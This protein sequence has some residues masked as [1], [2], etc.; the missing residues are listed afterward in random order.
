[1]VSS[2]MIDEYDRFGSNSDLSTIFMSIKLLGK[3]Q[4]VTWKAVD[5]W[6]QIKDT[7]DW[8]KYAEMTVSIAFENDKFKEL[9]PEGQ[10]EHL[11]TIYKSAWIK[12]RNRPKKGKPGRRIERNNYRFYIIMVI[13]HRTRLS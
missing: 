6:C 2:Y 1:M 12:C 11:R 7:N 5:K 3:K 4:K 10:L 9:S 13:L 8:V